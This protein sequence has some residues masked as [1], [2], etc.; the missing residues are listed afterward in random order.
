MLAG[1]S[2]LIGDSEAF[3]RPMGRMDTPKEIANGILFLASDESSYMTGTELI[4][5]G[6]KL[7]GQWR[8]ADTP[9]GMKG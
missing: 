8:L 9:Y 6:G 3:N 7:S 2:D 5:A 1:S 4:I